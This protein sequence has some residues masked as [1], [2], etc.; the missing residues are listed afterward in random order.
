MSDDA[1]YKVSFFQRALIL[2]PVI[3]GTA[4]HALDH[5]IGADQDVGVSDTKRKWRWT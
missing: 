3:K 5:P 4:V 2:I 1:V